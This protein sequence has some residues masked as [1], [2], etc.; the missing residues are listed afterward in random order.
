MDGDD[1]ELTHNELVERLN[2]VTMV[3]TAKQPTA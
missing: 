2:K 1:G 3:A